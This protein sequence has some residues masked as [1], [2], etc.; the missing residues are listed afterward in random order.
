MTLS[1]LPAAGTRSATHSWFT[2]IAMQISGP[3]GNST[4][5]GPHVPLD[6]NNGAGALRNC[7]KHLCQGIQRSSPSEKSRLGANPFAGLTETSTRMTEPAF[8]AAYHSHKDVLYRFACRMTGSAAAAEDI[9][10]DCFLALWRNP[11]TYDPSRRALQAFLLGMAR[12]LV[13]KRWPAQ[14]PH[15][16]LE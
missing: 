13:L 15:D 4:T 14:R 2:S 7:P 1:P 8:Q 3:T 11:Q 12:N 10:K 5:F 6:P 9:A 16:P